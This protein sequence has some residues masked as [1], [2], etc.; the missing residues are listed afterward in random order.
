MS[1]LDNTIS[2]R[3]LSKSRPDE[4]FHQSIIAALREPI[5]QPIAQPDAISA[6]FITLGEGLRKLPYRQRTKLEIKF[7]SMILEEQDNLDNVN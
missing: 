1:Y 2:K 5:A 6:F 7:L 4:E 3:K